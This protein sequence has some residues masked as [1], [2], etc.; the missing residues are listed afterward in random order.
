MQIDTETILMTHSDLRTLMRN[1]SADLHWALD[2]GIGSLTD[3]RAYQAYVTGSHCFRSALEPAMAEAEALTGWQPLFLA[4][5]LTQ[6]MRQLG[7][8]ASAPPTAP[9]LG[10]RASMLGALYVLEGS[11]LGAVL[12]ARRAAALGFDPESGAKH[13]AR[14]TSDPRRWSRFQ[15]FLQQPGIDADAACTAARAVFSLALT[16]F[17]VPQPALANP[18]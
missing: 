9:K 10:D 18:G 7:L 8:T 11:S 16:A 14:Q 2:T 1:R 4:K 17:R 15:A 6:D 3:H 12:L 5:E 13:L